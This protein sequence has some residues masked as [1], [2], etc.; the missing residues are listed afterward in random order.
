[1]PS[2]LK[3]IYT[4]LFTGG[5]D[6]DTA[7]E[8]MPNDRYRYMLNCN[9]FDS[10]GGN[11]G[12]VTNVKGNVNIPVP[13]P[14]GRCKTIGWASDEEKNNMYFFVWNINGYHGIYRFN[15][16]D[17][18][19][20]KVMECITDTGGVDIFGWE[21]RDLILSANVI[22]N[23][24]LYWT[25]RGDNRH[26]ARKINIS[27]ALDR[28]LT[29]YN[30][31]IKEEYTRA[32]K[33]TAS[34]P[35][36]AD[37][38]TDT[39]RKYNRLYGRQFKFATRYIY[40]DGEQSNWSSFSSVPLPDFERFSGSL[41]VP[42]E[43]NG[44][45]IYINTGGF[46]VKQIEIAMMSTNPDGGVFN[47]VTIDTV[48]KEQLDLG[49]NSEYIYAFYNDSSTEAIGDQLKVYRNYSY[50]PKDPRTQEFT[51]NALIYSNFHEGFPVVDVDMSATVRYEDIFI[52]DE[53]ENEI[54]SPSIDVINITTD[55]NGEWAAFNRDVWKAIQGTLV[56][57]PDVKKGNL[58]LFIL[59]DSKKNP[60]YLHSVLANWGDTAKT[61]A[62]KFASKFRETLLRHDGGIYGNDNGF[63]FVDEVQ[64]DLSGNASFEFKW[65]NVKDAPY[66][67]VST[68]V[69]PVQT[70]SL[71]NAGQSVQNIKLGS[72]IGYAISYF[73]EDG[74]KS[75]AYR[76]YNSTV[77][78]DS[79]NTLG[80][81]K[82]PVVSLEI[83]HTPPSWARYYQIVRTDDLVYGNYI[84]MLIQKT[85]NYTDG[86]DEYLDL[87]VG[88]LF[89]YQRIHP[90]TTLKYEFKKG[91]RVRLVKVFS[92][93]SESIPSDAL[94]YEVLGYYPLVEEQVDEDIT[95]D[96]SSTVVVQSATT[97]NIGNFIRVNGSERE[98]LDAP[99]GTSYTLT[100]PMNSGDPSHDEKTFT[101]YQIINRRGV[102]RIKNNPDNPIVADPDTSTFPVVEIYSPSIGDNSVDEDMYHEFGMVL[103]IINAGQD[104][105]YHGGS[106]QDQSAV[107]PAIVEISSGTSYVRYRELPVTNDPN[108]SQVIVTEIEDP[109]YSDFY[110]SNL[111]DN[112]KRIPLDRGDGEV[113][114]DER[115][116]FSNNYIEGTRI[117]G[118]N[119]FDNLDR[120]DY[121]DK[122][123]AIELIWYEDGR[124]YVFKHLKDGWIPIY[125]SI[126][127][128]QN[129]NPLLA[130]SDKLLADSIQYFAFDGG[131]GDN[132][133]SVVK[134]G[135]QFFH[136]SPNAMSAVR[137]GGNGVDSISK[138]YHL[139]RDV[140]AMLTSAKKA[141]AHIFGGADLR[142]DKYDVSIESH[143]NVI[144]DT[145]ITES[146]WNND[147]EELPTSGVTY[148]IVSGP[149]H[150]TL[151]V[152][153]SV[154]DYTPDNG[155]S[156][157]DTFS[158]EVFVGGVSQG[159]R[160]A[161]ITVTY[162]A[163]P[164]A[165]R[166]INSYCVLNNGARTGYQ[167]WNTLE[168][169]D[170]YSGDPTGV[171]KPNSSSD[172]D[173]VAPVYNTTSCS[174]QTSF[175]LFR[176][177]STDSSFE[178]QLNTSSSPVVIRAVQGS[179]ELDVTGSS[180]GLNKSIDLSGNTGTAIVY[181]IGDTGIEDDVVR[182]TCNSNDVVSERMNQFPNLNWFEFRDNNLSALSINNSDNP[183]LQ[184]ILYN[185]NSVTNFNP[186]G[187]GS[188]F[189]VSAGFNGINSVGTITGVPA[190]EEVSY[191]G[192]NLTSFPITSIPLI[193]AV[194]LQSNNL[195][196]AGLG[197]STPI[198]TIN[199]L[200]LADNPTLLSFDTSMFP[201][202][203]GLTIDKTE[204]PS[205]DMTNIP[206]IVYLDITQCPISSFNIS[207]NN[208]LTDLFCGE[209]TFTDDAA[210]PSIIDAVIIK[211]DS[212]ITSGGTLHYDVATSPLGIQP[213][214]A[215]RAAY[216]SLVGKGCE[217][218]GKPP[219]TA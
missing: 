162:Q 22:G 89:T 148:S 104:N 28:S 17:R 141:Q 3:D 66:P 27:K 160:N 147:M 183:D 156:G 102:I 193:R 30:G 50:L 61:I 130:K 36:R 95:V 197:V 204:V 194:E 108:N 115:M 67:S 86:S 14:A 23:E 155:Y 124:L 69:V 45:N 114:F 182:I 211:M 198:S 210:D 172:P 52:P 203:E 99:T 165:W 123:G 154:V 216:D 49:D 176:T 133:E 209:C 42:L 142:N 11:M 118:L 110:V 40:D 201:N 195:T 125:G 1:M 34:Y 60:R 217:L 48:D 113:L 59:Y 218:Q 191:P 98:I 33:R 94:D 213:T 13:L 2:P 54:N 32:Y 146:G 137:I 71:K 159:I 131:V 132:P 187:F 121:N 79:I 158:Y 29:G 44:I 215:S 92:G 175:E 207:T 73:D 88:S 208:N 80:G 189:N 111:Y 91:D 161:C 58:F 127:T 5:M 144:S 126:I 145:P 119:D 181:V 9:V 96:G 186:S 93:N 51:N 199:N 37:Y 47:W 164:P 38:F 10:V 62:Q 100:E 122:Y 97:D 212:N 74:R 53:T 173:Y 43:N 64:V 25:T 179:T 19:V 24:L 171:T 78:I 46:L 68:S 214:V 8:Q 77:A 35:P 200:F 185:N 20:I 90:N 205:I 190:L 72:S 135:T 152:S 129:D 120:V 84:Q 136:I 21:E 55:R 196:W 75:A 26:P 6:S 177:T 157:P 106:V 167:G 134:I 12:V 7:P 139:N 170:T 65:W 206:D 31:T 178:F 105:A 83:S 112:G 169:Y 56:I 138:L 85:V 143:D 116:R 103:P 149:S 180:S 188:L 163:G 150:G 70:N 82:K 166:P 39:N 109:S 101:S 76:D 4:Q 168:Q 81:I 15:L 18:A 41:S 219:L 117:N 107:Q 63:A 202:L 16:V 192:N 174:I 184:Y 151:S 87:V 57:G 128:D 140:R 153:G